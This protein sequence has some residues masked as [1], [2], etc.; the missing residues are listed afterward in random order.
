LLLPAAAAGA[1]AQE[2]PRRASPTSSV[3]GDVPLL[4]DSD[5]E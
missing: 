4:R 1:Q 5:D 3:G 2:L